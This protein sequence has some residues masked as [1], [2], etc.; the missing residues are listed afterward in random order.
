VFEPSSPDHRTMRSGR[1]DSRT[2]QDLVEAIT[3][4]TPGVAEF[5]PYMTALLLGQKDE[6]P[7]HISGSVDFV[8]SGVAQGSDP[9][10]AGPAMAFLGLRNLLRL[11]DP[12]LPLLDRVRD[13]SAV[14]EVFGSRLRECA[15]LDDAC[16]ARIT[17]PFLISPGVGL[18]PLDTWM[19]QTAALL[20]DLRGRQEWQLLEAQARRKPRQR[21]SRSW[22]GWPREHLLRR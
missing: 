1:G 12:D 8:P 14:V 19:P 7:L 4:A 2:S 17:N 6:I 5:A 9:A 11:H 20:E 16:R 13:H 3:T 18:L 21:G 15:D 22:R 10:Q